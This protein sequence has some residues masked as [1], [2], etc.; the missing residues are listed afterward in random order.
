MQEDRRDNELAYTLELFTKHPE[1]FIQKY[2][3]SADAVIRDKNNDEFYLLGGTQTLLLTVKKKNPIF[4]I[5]YPNENIREDKV[6]LGSF[7][8]FLIPTYP[9]DKIER[10]DQLPYVVL[11]ARTNTHLM[12]TTSLSGCTLCC[13]QHPDGSMLVTHVQPTK[14]PGAGYENRAEELQTELERNGMF[15]QHPESKGNIIFLGQEIIV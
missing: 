15:N 3:L 11:P 8:A 12:I 2:Y 14:P 9:E 10:L 1:T 6:S 13:W 5:A 4:S 7:R